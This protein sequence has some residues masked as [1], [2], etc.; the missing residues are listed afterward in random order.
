MYQAKNNGGSHK[1]LSPEEMSGKLAD[2][3]I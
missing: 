1:V 2:D 3:L